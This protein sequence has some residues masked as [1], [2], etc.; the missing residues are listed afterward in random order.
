MSQ[1]GTGITGQ[2][3]FT[4]FI[5]RNTG[6]L[7]IEVLLKR[8][9]D[10]LPYQFGGISDAV[11]VSDERLN[12]LIVHGS[13]RTREMVAELLEV[14]DTDD[15]PDFLN[16]YQPEMITLQNTQATRVLDILNNV[17][18][19]QLTTRGSSRSPLRVP[20]GVGSSVAS[21]LQQMNAAASG[22]LLTLEVDESSNSL[23]VRAPPELRD[24]I[25][26]FAQQIDLQAATR[27]NRHVR[28]IQLKRSKSD[29][30]QTVLEHFLA[31]Q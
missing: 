21:M 13:V 29:R 8:L 12:A 6:A 2:S 24:E 26:Q 23:I 1:A 15:L 14:L 30:M 31:D 10:E 9:F 22:P 27:S 20:R 28:V 3:N 25:R 16:I 7:E 5:L 17:Y 18:R 4:V 11:V 19:S